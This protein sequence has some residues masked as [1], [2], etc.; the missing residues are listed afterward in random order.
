MRVRFK[1]LDVIEETIKQGK[2]EKLD[3]SEVEFEFEDDHAKL[4]LDVVKR[5]RWGVMDEEIFAC[6]NQVV[7]SFQ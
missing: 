1:I 2:S 5:Q 6:V 7:E 4:I 3:R